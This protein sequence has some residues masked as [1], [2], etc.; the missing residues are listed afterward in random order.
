MLTCVQSQWIDPKK[1][2]AGLYLSQLVPTGDDKSVELAREFE[3]AVYK[4]VDGQ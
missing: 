3:H 4:A 1:G 2:V